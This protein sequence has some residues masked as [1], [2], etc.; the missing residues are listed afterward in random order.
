M[1]TDDRAEFEAWALADGFEVNRNKEGYKTFETSLAWDVWQGARTAPASIAAQELT[2]EQIECAV[3]DVHEAMYGLRTID[4]NAT[5]A[6][7]YRML[8]NGLLAAAKE[9]K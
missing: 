6:R 1:I 4:Y 3:T 5:D 9:A 2:D 7:Y 8:F